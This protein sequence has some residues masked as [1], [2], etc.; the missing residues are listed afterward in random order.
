MKTAQFGVRKLS[1]VCGI[2]VVLLGFWLRTIDV[3]WDHDQ[4]LHPDERFLT[5]VMG[6]MEFPHSFSQY[7]D[8]Q[9]SKLNPAN[10]NYPFFVYGILPLT[11]NKSIAVLVGN[12]SYTK[13]T[14]QGRALSAFVD[15]ISLLTLMCIVKQLEKK[16]RLRRELKY[17]AGLLYAVAVFPIQQSHFFTV[18]TFSVAFILL[19]LFFALRIESKGWFIFS[20]LSGIF[21]GLALGSKVNVVLVGPL[22]AALM[23]EPF[24][25]KWWMHRKFSLLAV[26]KIVTMYILFS[27]FGVLFL[28]LANPYYFESG[29]LFDWR[30]SSHFIENIKTLQSFND[31]KGYFP[32]SIQWMNKTPLLFP[33]VNIAVFGVGL[34]FFFFAIFGYFY[35]I[36]LVIHKPI[37]YLSFF[38]LSGWCL[39]FFLYQ[40]SQFVSTMRYFLVL[41]PFLAFWAALGMLELVDFLQQFFK[42]KKRSHESIVGGFFLLCC[43]WTLMFMSIYFK[44]HT[45]VTAS[46]WMYKVLPDGSMLALEH[47]DDPLPLLIEHANGDDKN[48]DG[49]QMPV[50]YPDDEKKWKEMQEIM[51]KADYYVLTSNRAWGSIPTVPDKYPQ[52]AKFYDDLFAGKTQWVKMTEFTSYPSLEYLGIPVSLNDDWA[53][54]AFS[55][56][57]HPKVIV[58]RKK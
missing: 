15:S 49:K 20:S 53:E 18:D 45:R 50:F 31:P 39:V 24:F 27:L 56:Y 6:A 57:D 42:W 26:L 14:V 38:F 4:H 17:F 36:K 21:F 28:R 43:I 34:P 35:T 16:L 13:L 40:G 7:L 8:P 41:Y 33:F 2:F 30:I 3:N 10:I 51:D 52:M 25:A 1:V 58:F 44:P 29:N 55:V 5:M 19:S 12:D 11:V 32:P 48:I 9:Q 54:E 47:W 22:L 46:L 37:K 23:L